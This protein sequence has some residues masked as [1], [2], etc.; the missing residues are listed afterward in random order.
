MGMSFPRKHL[1][2][3][4]AF[5]S[6]LGLVSGPVSAKKDGDNGKS[7]K[8]VDVVPSTPLP[9]SV[10][11]NVAKKVPAGAPTFIVRFKSGATGS[12]VEAALGGKGANRKDFTNGKVGRLSVVS[13]SPGKGRANA[14]KDLE[15]LSSVI[16]LCEE[17]QAIDVAPLSVVSTAAV[18]LPVKSWGLDR[19]DQR[20][21][22]YDNSYSYATTGAGVN[23]YVVDTGVLSTHTDLSGRVRTGFDA[24][25]LNSTEDCNGH[26]THVAGTIAGA[27]YGVAPAATVVPIRVLKC[28]GSG[29]LSGVIAG[30]DW[31]I[32]DHAKTPNVR[33]VMNLSLGGGSSLSLN[34]AVL[35]ATQAG[36]TVVA[37]AGNSSGADACDFSPAGADRNESSEP[38]VVITVGATT[39]TDTR[40]S[41]SNVGQCVD[42]FAPGSAITSAWHTS[43]T[44]TQTISGTSMAA[45]HVAGV[46]ARVLSSN[47]T[48]T[49]AQVAAVIK[50]N[51]TANVVVDAQSPSNLLLFA[52]PE[53][54][55]VTPPATTGENLGGGTGELVAPAAP[56]APIAVAGD[57]SASLRWSD[58]NT[59]SS[60]ITGHSVRVYSGTRLI[61]EVAG[62]S[63][64][65][66]TVTG[67]KAGT[68]YTFRVAAIN[69]IGRSP[70]SDLSNVAVPVRILRNKQPAARAESAPTSAP[71]VARNVRVR[72]NG[73][74]LVASWRY[75]QKDVGVNTNF[76]VLVRNRDGLVARLSVSDWQGV[77]L[78]G[79]KPGSYSV[80]VRA[81]NPVGSARASKSVSA[82]IR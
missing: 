9:E 5:A 79:L 4:I 70:F 49:P 21:R 15:T 60:T 7:R 13:F 55:V 78:T 10:V 45:P 2:V 11:C 20:S 44:A 54:T 43:A 72:V 27:T 75:A 57:R 28:D 12:A 38:H 22:I 34:E 81:K 47:T 31:A 16:E 35:R 29:T 46:A 1:V 73:K 59:G 36:I 64:T 32:A 56:N 67:L 53:A 48:F 8:P 62:T 52:D 50:T 23:A 37:A 14:K 69:S 26:G 41:Y 71:G 6:V 39:S 42:V 25:G 82:K 68:S 40:A 66:A 51:A 77:T 17:D 63:S 24:T 3:G 80:R 30:I 74:R 61:K 18:N 76:V 65:T 33:A 58:N 19:I